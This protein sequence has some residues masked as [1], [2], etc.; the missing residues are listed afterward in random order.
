LYVLAN[1]YIRRGIGMIDLH[2][3]YCLWLNKSN[4]H[5]YLPALAASF[6]LRLHYAAR[7]GRC[8]QQ[9]CENKQL[10]NIFSS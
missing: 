5:F 4:Q 10:V 9:R 1:V 7:A 2:I 3:I 6:R 8:H